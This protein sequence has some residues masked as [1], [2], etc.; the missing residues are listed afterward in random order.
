MGTYQKDGGGYLWEGD[1]DEEYYANYYY[2]YG[3]EDYYYQEQYGYEDAYGEEMDTA[4]DI[5]DNAVEDVIREERQKIISEYERLE[6]LAFDNDFNSL[7]E[8]SA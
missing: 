1:A 6:M 7:I 8:E 5:Q 3:N 2:E 4:A